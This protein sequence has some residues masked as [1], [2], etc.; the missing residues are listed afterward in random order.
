MLKALER[1]RQTMKQGPWEYC[2]DTTTITRRIA[3]YYLLAE[4][5][6]SQTNRLRT[7][8]G[9]IKRRLLTLPINRSCSILYRMHSCTLFHT[10]LGVQVPTYYLLRVP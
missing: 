3:Y 2:I 7:M 1:D 8:D 9:S 10:K 6:A 4:E 5:D